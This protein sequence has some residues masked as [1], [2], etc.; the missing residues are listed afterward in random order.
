MKKRPE[1]WTIFPL[2]SGFESCG[3]QGGSYKFMVGINARLYNCNFLNQ[4]SDNKPGEK[5]EI[6]VRNW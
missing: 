4:Y 1:T 5:M 3:T 6:N 2:N